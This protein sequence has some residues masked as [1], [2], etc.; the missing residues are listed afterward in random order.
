V[1]YYDLLGTMPPLPLLL[2]ANGVGFIRKVQVGYNL[3]DPNSISTCLIYKIY[4]FYVS[5]DVLGG[6]IPSLDLK[7]EWADSCWAPLS[8]SPSPVG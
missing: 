1:V 4:L 7:V 8:F 5:L 6:G 2:Y 3:S